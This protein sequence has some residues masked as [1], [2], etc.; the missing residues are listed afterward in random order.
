[1]SRFTGPRLKIMR[2]LGV[3]LP[4]LSR[5]ST[6]RKAY[7]PGMHGAMR[8]RGKLSVFGQQLQEKQK[9]RFNYGL[10]E[11]QLRRTI[12]EAFRLRGNPG[13]AILQLLEERLDNTVFRAGF[14]PTIPAARQIVNHG[15]IRVNGKRVDICSYRIKSGDVIT[16]GPKAENMPVVVASLEAPSLARPAW[17][18]FDESKKSATVIARPDRE[19][20]PF[21][22]EIN[23]VVEYYSSRI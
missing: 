14:A 12:K 11:K 13:E 5:K 16:I 7:P 10:R 4:G 21:P 6:E 18:S 3:Q 22:V 8:K 15:H 1:M 17:L 23:L 9:L 20:V 19:S 2:G